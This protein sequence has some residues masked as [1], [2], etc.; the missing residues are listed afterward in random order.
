M[1][2]LATALA[3][4]LVSLGLSA[5]AAPAP[6]PPAVSYAQHDESTNELGVIG[7]DFGST[8]P[9]VTLSGFQLVVSAF[10]NTEIIAAIP[11]AI[12][13]G[14]YILRISR[15]GKN[16]ALSEAFYVAL[17][18]TGAAGPQGPPGPQGPQGVQG[19]QGTQGPQ[20]ANGM[21][22]PAGPQ[23]VPGPQGPQGI[24]GP[25][26]PQ[27]PGLLARTL[28]R[29]NTGNSLA[30]TSAYALVRTLGSFT[31]QQAGTVVKLTWTSHGSVQGSFCDFQLRIDGTTDEGTTDLVGLTGAG[32]A[33]LW[34]TFGTPAMGYPFSVSAVYAGLGAGARNVE[35]YVRGFATM[36]NL[37]DGN[38]PELVI[39]EEM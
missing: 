2:V 31:K 13:P 11:P 7:T 35:V 28:L 23:G 17:G 10:S 5:H 30:P 4:L 34:N 12:E 25:Q 6:P 33:V 8:A 37:N 38:F 27:G 36:C 29:Y 24:T 20:G 21:T 19:T 39:V 15:G 22:G 26:G 3:T 16:P 18:A 1:K 32:R 9:I 14:T